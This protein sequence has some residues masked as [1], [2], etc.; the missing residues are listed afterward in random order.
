M[1]VTKV[2]QGWKSTTR[3]QGENTTL[4]VV[5]FEIDS[6]PY[7]GFVVLKESGELAMPT[8]FRMTYQPP[9]EN[10]GVIGSEDWKTGGEDLSMPPEVHAAVEEAARKF[11]GYAIA[12]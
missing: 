8:Y 6:K 4:A 10:R 3:R 5:F 11:A 9:M 7:C 1:K 2:I 12:A